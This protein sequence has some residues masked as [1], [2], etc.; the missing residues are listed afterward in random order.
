MYIIFFVQ[1]SLQYLRTFIWIMNFIWTLEV[2]FLI[3]CSFLLYKLFSVAIYTYFIFILAKYSFILNQVER[4]FLRILKLFFHFLT[5]SIAIHKSN[6]T[7]GIIPIYPSSLF[8]S[9]LK[10]FLFI[11]KDLQ[12]QIYSYSFSLGVVELPESDDWYFLNQF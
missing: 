2:P 1:H 10:V 5:S 6:A 12:M 9:A 3:A 8:S 11:L 4:I 7:V